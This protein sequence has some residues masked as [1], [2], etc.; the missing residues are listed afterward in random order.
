MHALCALSTLF[1]QALLTLPTTV[2]CPSDFLNDTSILLLGATNTTGSNSLPSPTPSTFDLFSSRA[3]AIHFRIPNTPFKLIFGFF[4]DLIPVSE[5]SAAFEGAHLQIVGPLGQHPN[6]PIPGDRFEYGRSGVRISVI[7]NRETVMT[8]RQLSTVLGGLYGF[9][10]GPP[11]HIQLVTCEISFTG[12]GNMGFASVWYYPPRLQVT[13]R[14]QPNRNVPLPLAPTPI[15]FIRFSVPET[16]IILTFSYFGLL[17]PWR[18][19]EDAIS[20]VLEQ[21]EPCYREHGT[22]PV[23]G[24]HF[25]RAFHAVQITLFANVPYVM[26]WIQLHSIVWGLLLF[27]TGAEGAGGHYRVLSFNVDDVRAG[28]AAY[29]TLRDSEPRAVDLP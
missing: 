1:L 19:L 20:A 8:W 23:P 11:E 15:A 10:T 12:R 25:F 5:V 16:P 13:K 2:F 4:G 6:S 24:N 7:V 17:I 22:D 27:V 29:G 14:A 3:N 28:K 21:I 9:M 18:E 26:S